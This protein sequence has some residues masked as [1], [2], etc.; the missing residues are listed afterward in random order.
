MSN[1]SVHVCPSVT[2]VSPLGCSPPNAQNGTRSRILG[3]VVC[4]IATIALA[5]SKDVGTR[6][7]KRPDLGL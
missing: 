6:V 3:H 7:P 2:G 4:L 1:R 5:A